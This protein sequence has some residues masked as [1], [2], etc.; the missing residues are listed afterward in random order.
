MKA[1]AGRRW[2]PAESADRR[3]LLALLALAA[4]AFAVRLVGVLRG[5]GL[6]GDHGFDDSVY[7]G[8]AIALVHDK[9]P[10]RDFNIL[11]PPGIIYLLSPF[12]ALGGVTGDAT[13]FAIARLGFMVLGAINTVLVGMVARTG[14]RTAAVCAAGL[15]AVWTVPVNVEHTAWLIAPQTALLLLA[16]LQLQGPV[17]ALSARRVALAGVLIGLSGMIQ[18]WAAVPAFTVLGWLLVTSRSDVRTG[19]RRAAAYCTGGILAVLVLALPMFLTSGM[20]MI[21]LVVVTQLARSGGGSPVGKVDRIRMLEGLPASGFL[22]GVVPDALAVAA[23]VAAAGLIAFVAWRRPHT[24]LWTALIA[25]KVAFLLYTAVFYNHYSGWLAPEATLLGGT[26]VAMAIGSLAGVPKR[27]ALGAFAVVLALVAVVSLHGTG[28]K[29]PLTS[30]LPDLS[31]AGCVTADSPLLLINTGA[32]R[33]N[34]ERGCP[35]LLNPGGLS[36]I[37]NAQKPG[38]NI[39]RIQLAE[40]QQAMR[41]FYSSGDAAMFVRLKEDQLSS[42]TWAHLQSELP[43]KQTVGPVTVLFRSQP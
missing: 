26:A 42:E 16:L 25:G 39:P 6:T 17:H 2:L 43:V 23:F 34:L 3:L 30:S 29:I 9:L 37:I 38:P 36:N 1:S 31:Q 7:F 8:A 24:R 22:A 15:Y 33:R 27:A 20:R 5:G 28:Q 21:Q 11:H 40:Y 19:L 10:Y 35:L 14:G 18:V 12:A 13:A 41:D 4:V 32:H